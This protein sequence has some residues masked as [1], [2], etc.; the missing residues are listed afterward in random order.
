MTY[1]RQGKSL[2]WWEENID[3]LEHIFRFHPD[4]EKLIEKMFH[5]ELT[6][7]QIDQAFDE[8]EEFIQVEREKKSNV[9]IYD[10]KA[11]H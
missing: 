9:N 11:F 5:L 3:Q 8:A 7:P 1:Q 6:V 2:E 4:R 10:R